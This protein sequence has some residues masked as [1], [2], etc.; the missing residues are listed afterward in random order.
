M[1][2]TY[3]VEQTTPQKPIGKQNDQRRG[4]WHGQGRGYGCHWLGK[5]INTRGKPLKNNIKC[6][7]ESV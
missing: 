6:E 3:G 5:G 1:L 7:N 2:S 4:R